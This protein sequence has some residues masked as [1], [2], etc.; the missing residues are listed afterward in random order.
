MLAE[1]PEK[2]ELHLSAVYLVCQSVCFMGVDV[3][4]HTFHN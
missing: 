3:V 1:F 4:Y 2:F